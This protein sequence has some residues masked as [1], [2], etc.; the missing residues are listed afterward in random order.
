MV[1]ND[2]TGIWIWT[3]TNRT[4]FINSLK[5]YSTLLSTSNPLSRILILVIAPRTQQMIKISVNT[6]PSFLKALLIL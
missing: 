2:Q 4:L 1:C 6:C 5:V 3:Q